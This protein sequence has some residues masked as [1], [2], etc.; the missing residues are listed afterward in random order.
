MKFHN[1][2][3]MGLGVSVCLS[4][5]IS[6][7]T[8]QQAEER[9]AYTIHRVTGDDLSTNVD[10]AA[11]Q[12]QPSGPSQP[13]QAVPFD[14]APRLSVLPGPQRVVVSEAVN[15]RG[16][17]PGACG[18]T[19]VTQNSDPDTVLIG[20]GTIAFGGGNGTGQ[21]SWA[22]CF[23]GSDFPADI[24]LQCVDV[25]IEQNTS[26]GNNAFDVDLRI[27]ELVNTPAFPSNGCPLPAGIDF[28]DPQLGQT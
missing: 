2:I 14:G 17:V 4:L 22:R 24:V 26:S 8:A 23:P 19:T 16:E 15:A 11:S 18:D 28:G 5:A 3:P 10:R 25:G 20:L 27:V 1:T 13:V 9:T 12:S 7:T 6:T 21:N